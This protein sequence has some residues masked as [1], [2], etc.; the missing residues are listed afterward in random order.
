MAETGDVQR[1]AHSV[2]PRLGGMRLAGAVAGVAAVAVAAGVGLP[3]LADQ[4]APA[5]HT[6]VTARSLTVTIPVAAIPLSDTELK[7]LLDDPA[8]L[9]PLHNRARRASCL[10]GLGYPAGTAVL[11][12]RTVA[13]NRRPALVLLLPGDVPGAVNVLA[14]DPRCNAADTGLVVATTITR[15]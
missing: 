13:I 11:G 8:D 6:I 7:A 4:A 15:P 10:A 1:P 12:A 9:G 14:V 3:A 2:T 5:A